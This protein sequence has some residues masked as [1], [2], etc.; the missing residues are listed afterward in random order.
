MIY[1]DDTFNILF[2]S[3]YSVSSVYRKSILFTVCM[4]P[5]LSRSL[6]P[7]L[8]SPPVSNSFFPLF[9]SLT[10]C[11]QSARKYNGN[12]PERSRSEL[13][14]EIKLVPFV[15]SSLT[16]GRQIARE[17]SA[18]QGIR[19]ASGVRCKFRSI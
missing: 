14:N 2:I 7:S 15:D 1:T 12:Q 3:R 10:V 18:V 8:D 19:R 6:T 16:D 11:T 4:P 9:R 5:L 17:R 13:M